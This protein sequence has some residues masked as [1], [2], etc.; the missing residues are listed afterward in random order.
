[1]LLR[2]YQEES[3]SKLF[4]YWAHDK[5]KAPIIAAPTGSGKSLII[6]E[7]CRRVCMDCPSVKIMVLA[8]VRELLTQ[9]EKELKSLWPEANTGIYSAGLGKRQIS[10]QITFAGIQSVY[11]RVFEFGKVDI[12][13]V[14]EC[15]LIPRDAD[16][17][18]GKFFRDMKLANPDVAIFGLSASPYRLDSGMLHEGKDA[19]F[20]GIAYSVD[21]KKLIHDG[22]L[23][24]VISKGGSMQDQSRRR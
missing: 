19:L 1:M 11:S 18:Y 17:R 10:A 23:V 14:D 7:F 24:D 2:D 21:I 3:L 8:H 12:V 6:A 15:H 4:E 22:Y 20:D 16:T 9:N 13:I 5:G